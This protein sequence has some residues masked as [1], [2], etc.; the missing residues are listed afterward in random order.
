MKRTLSDDD[1]G[2][3]L[4]GENDSILPSSG[5]V[6]SVMAAIASREAL[7]PEIPFPW[8]QALPGLAASA[9]VVMLLA[10]AFVFAF[11]TWTP[12][13]NVPAHLQTLLDV[14]P[15]NLVAADA[16]P[17][18]AA[19]AVTLACLALTRRLMLPRR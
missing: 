14:V 12:S 9:V 4:S 17:M 8:K 15:A 11:R 6:S 3:A 18:L 13:A 1:L 2:R 5:F 10:A 19:L 16:R 7:P